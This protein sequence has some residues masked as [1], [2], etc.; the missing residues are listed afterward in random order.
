MASNSTATKVGH[1]LAKVL[2]IKLHYRNPQ[3]LDDVSRGESVYSVSSA[4]SYVEQ[5]PSTWEWIQ[6]VIPTGRGLVRWAY[7]LF[8]FVHWIGRYNVQ[9]L[10]GD[11]VA[12]KQLSLLLYTARLILMLGI[13]VGCVVVPQSMAY[14]RLAE[15]A[16]EYGLYSSFMGVLVYWF[17]A[18][19]KD[20][21][22]GVSAEWGEPKV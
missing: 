2:G 4:D 8:P 10:Y 6:S 9:W 5:E 12:G 22:I 17:F 18:T 11:L 20:I 16:P 15:L 1:G 3:G 13:T 7:N 21:T 19:S 14:A